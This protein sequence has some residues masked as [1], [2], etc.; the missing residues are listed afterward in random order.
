[1]SRR[2]LLTGGSGSIGSAIATRLRAGDADDVRAPDRA[3]LDL[4]SADSVAHSIA[5]GACEGLDVL[6][7]CAGFNEPKPALDVDRAAMLQSLEIN[8]LS[9]LE[10]TRAVVPSMIA[11]GAGRILAVGSLYASRSQV[12]RLAYTAS[13]HALLG[14]TRTLA[15]EIGPHGIV[16]NTVSPG[17]VYTAMTRR[18]NGPAAIA[19]L[20]QA[21]PL[22][23]LAA[24]DELA[25]VVAFLVSPE[26]TYIHGQDIVVDGG[27][28]VGWFSR[29]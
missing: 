15:M 21:V 20:E 14:A 13:K 2:I 3:A 5:S 1:M 7:H 11:R 18:N 29:G 4:A 28:S 8:L 19:A 10:L 24:P 25:N 26:N 6:I 12:R 23:R 17:F 9:F 16:V 27:F 22:G